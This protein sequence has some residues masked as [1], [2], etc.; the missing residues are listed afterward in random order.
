MDSVNSKT[1]YMED[2]LRLVAQ[3]NRQNKN[4][5]TSSLN[6]SGTT[7]KDNKFLYAADQLL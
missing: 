1:T 3:N 2:L 7:F 5:K 4:D 6:N